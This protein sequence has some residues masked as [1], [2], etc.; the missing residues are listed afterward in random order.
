MIQQGSGLANGTWFYRVSAVSSEGEG[1]ASREVFAQGGGVMRICWSAVPAATSYNIYRSL[2]ADGRFGTTRLLVPEFV[3]TPNA[4]GLL[5]FDD[6]GQNDVPQGIYRTPAPGRLAGSIGAGGSLL[7]GTWSYRVAAVRDDNETVAGYRTSFVVDATSGNTINL[8]WDIIPTATYNLYRVQNANDAAGSE[9]LL[10]TGLTGNSFVD[11]GTSGF[12]DDS[13]GP[14]DGIE[15]LPPGTLSRWE[16][17]PVTLTEARE[18]PDAVVLTAFDGDLNTTNDPTYLYVTGGK[19]S[20]QGTFSDGGNACLVNEDCLSRTCVGVAPNQTCLASGSH[21]TTERALVD[22]G[23]GALINPVDNAAVTLAVSATLLNTG[24]AYF[25]LLTN[26]G[27]LIT[28]FAPPPQEPPCGDVDGD[29]FLSTSCG[30]DDCNDANV[31][32]FPGAPEQCS[33]GIDDDCDALAD[34]DDPDA[35]PAGCAGDALCACD[36]A[37]ADSDGDGHLRA[38]LCGDDCNDDSSATCGNAAGLDPPD[39]A[40]ACGG[41]ADEDCDGAIDCFDSDCATAPNCLDACATAVDG[42]GDGELLP[43]C[44]ND[45]DDTEPTVCSTACDEVQCDGIDQDCS[46][47]DFCFL[48]GNVTGGTGGSGG[49]VSPLAANFQLVA[50]T[51]DPILLVACAGDAN[52][53]ANNNSGL[54][55]FEV[56]TINPVD[57]ELVAWTLQSETIPRD[58]HGQDALLFFDFLYNWSGVARESAGGDPAPDNGQ[59]TRVPFDVSPANANAHLGGRQSASSTLSPPRTYASIT[60]LNAKLFAIGGNDG[61]GAVSTVTR[62][63]Q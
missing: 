42:D 1:L 14:R 59:T 29:G 9:R 34:C 28:P 40:E 8:R 6:N 26:Q 25:P 51:N 54:Q 63:S 52:Y 37:F 24:R 19:P 17:L 5:C 11:D 58:A 56:A 7:Q 44:G 50:E 3:P 32:V 4:N 47:V 15:V 2:A 43:P 30:G 60:R 55:T 61:T 16:V 57:G 35:P 10:A 45:C 18:G 36:P 12:A 39:C 33:N 31:A 23:T 46:G 22:F 21:R 13:R 20:H 53:A 49:L 41:G 38:P 27:Q 62:N 48:P